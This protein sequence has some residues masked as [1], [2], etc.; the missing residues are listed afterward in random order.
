MVL[1]RILLCDLHAV[2][3]DINSA[4]IVRTKQKSRNGKDTA[5][6]AKVKHLVILV[7]CFFKQFKAKLSCVVLTCSE[8]GLGI[9]FKNSPVGLLQRL[10][11]G[12]YNKLVAHFKGLEILLPVVSPV[13]FTDVGKLTDKASELLFGIKSGKLS[14]LAPYHSQ[15]IC[16]LRII[17]KIE[18]YAGLAVFQVHKVIVDIIPVACFVVEEVLK[19]LSILYSKACNAYAKQSAADRLDTFGGGIN[20]YF[21]PVHIKFLRVFIYAL[22]LLL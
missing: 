14:H 1:F 16:T 2:K 19:I 9:Y 3:V 12:L 6:A 8:G 20:I 5:S 21:C 13:L 11:G 22:L 17:R 4:G 10:P 7:K 18:C 15:H